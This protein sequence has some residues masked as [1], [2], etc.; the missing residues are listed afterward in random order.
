[1]AI[2]RGT[3]RYPYFFVKRRQMRERKNKRDTKTWYCKNLC[4]DNTYLQ[5]TCVT[6]TFLARVPFLAFVVRGLTEWS[7]GLFFLTSFFPHMFL[8]SSCSILMMVYVHVNIHINIQSI[9]HCWGKN[10]IMRNMPE[11]HSV[12][13]L[14]TRKG[15]SG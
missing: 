4:E 8:R 13:P 10:D 2:M 14:T 1:M 7:I 11:L 5:S 15:P 6:L 9:K 3:K 12:R